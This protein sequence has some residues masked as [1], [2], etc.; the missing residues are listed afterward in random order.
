M[1]GGGL[2]KRNGFVNADANCVAVLW[3]VFHY[4]V[5]TSSSDSRAEKKNWDDYVAV[6]QQF[7]DTVIDRY[8]QGDISK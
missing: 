5:Q 1:F 3:P 7:A 2:W 6:N 4:L 8:Q